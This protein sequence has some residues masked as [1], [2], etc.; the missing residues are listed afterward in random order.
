MDTLDSTCW[1]LVDICFKTF[2]WASVRPFATSAA[3]GDVKRARTR[4]LNA[5][6]N[7]NVRSWFRSWS[8]SLWNDRRRRNTDSNAD[9]MSVLQPTKKSARDEEEEG[10]E[11]G[12]YLLS[13]TRERVQMERA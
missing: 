3:S 10:K 13:E 9:G 7:S 1:H 6:R 2:M 4:R 8:V 5:R 12:L 11:E